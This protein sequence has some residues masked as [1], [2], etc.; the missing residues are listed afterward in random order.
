MTI[1]FLHPWRSGFKVTLKIIVEKHTTGWPNFNVLSFKQ[2]KMRLSVSVCPLCGCMASLQCLGDFLIMR[3]MVSRGTSSQTWT[4]ASV[5]LVTARGATWSVEGARHNVPDVLNWIPVW[6]LGRPVH[7]NSA[8]ILQE[9][10]QPHE[11]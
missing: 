4:E 1:K 3:P 5:N 9:L 7:S 10:L 11:V 2:V 8:F 6:G